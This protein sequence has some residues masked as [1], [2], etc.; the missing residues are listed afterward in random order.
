MG[1][2]AG[3][4]A[5]GLELL[6]LPQ[7]GFQPP[8]LLGLSLQGEVGCCEGLRRAGPRIPGADGEG[9]DGQQQHVWLQGLAGRRDQHRHDGHGAGGYARSWGVRRLCMSSLAC[10]GASRSFE[11]A[12]AST[13]NKMYMS[14]TKYLR[15]R[16]GGL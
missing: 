10:I 2:A 14:L 16:I 15:R 8:P 6:G 7:L 1:H 13:A 11:R 9:G 5:D 3:Q 12:K 4:V